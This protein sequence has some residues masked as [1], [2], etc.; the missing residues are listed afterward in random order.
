MIEIIETS[1][2]TDNLFVWHVKIVQLSPL[3]PIVMFMSILIEW[4][5]TKEKHW[6]SNNFYQWHQTEP[7]CK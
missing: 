4:L 7:N 1:E 6:N 5:K 3:A 2:A